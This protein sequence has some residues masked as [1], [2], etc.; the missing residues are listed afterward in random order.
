[1]SKKH[2][3]IRRTNIRQVLVVC[4]LLLGLCTAITVF[5]TVKLQSNATDTVRRYADA[6]ISKLSSEL[7]N[8]NSAM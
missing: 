7:E 2:L 4:V 6:F 5:S 1:M 8:N 3:H